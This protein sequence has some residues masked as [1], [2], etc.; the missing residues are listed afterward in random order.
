[1]EKHVPY[2][3]FLILCLFV[4]FSACSPTRYV[5]K[6]EFLLN[7]V[8]VKVEEQ[9]INTSGLKKAIRQRP[10][11]RILG[12]ARF[13]LGLYN[14][15][16][17]KEEKWLN[18]WLRSIGEAPVIYSPFLT[19]QSKTQLQ[20][21][22]NN[23]GYYKARVTDS[24]WFKKKKAYVE[25]RVVP[26][27][28]TK[29]GEFDFQVDS[30]WLSSGKRDRYR[31][32]QMILNDSANSLVKKEMP[33]D[34]EVLE[35]ERERIAYMLRKN[36]YFN[37]S[38]KFIH[39]Y[40]DTLNGNFSDHAGLLMSIVS[41]AY[42]TMSFRK[43]RINH[44]RVNLD[45]D[46]LR[47][48]G[49]K[50]SLGRIIPCEGYEV[51]Y[52]D[53][54]KIK[55]KVILETLQF[56]KGDLYNIQKV[57]SSY[58]R[59]QAL[60]LFKFINIVF[61]EHWD[62]E[63]MPALDCEIQLT[64]MKRQSYNVFLEGTNNS[65]NIG[66]G[67]NFSYNHRNLFHGGENITWS[68]WGALKKERL[69][70]NE[71]FSA[72]EVGTELKLISPQFWMPVFRMAEFR[73]NFAPKTSVSLSY[74]QE[75]TR[76]YRRRIASAKF[77]YFWRRADNKWHYNFDL[78]DLNY[79][80]MPYMDASF[81]SEL[82][83]EYVKSAY[84]DHMILSANFSATYTDQVVN[85]SESYNYFRG[86]VETS[87]N[88]LL[89]IDRLLGSPRT[90]QNGEKFHKM[91]GVRYAQFVKADGEYRF[92]HYVNKA[93]TVVYR[94][95][96]G[97]GYPYGNMK[98]LPFEEA[99]FCGGANGIR[100]WQSRTL[101]PGAYS[102]GDSYP[103]NVGDFKLEANIEYRFKLFWLLE[104]ALFLD[105]GN[106]WNINRYENRPGAHLNADFYQ[107]LAVGTGIGL[108]LDANFF[109]L[110]FDLGVKMRD[111]SLPR[112]QK[113]VLLNHNGGFRES[114]FNIAI[115]YPF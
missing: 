68:F 61:K 31:L 21:Y 92:S 9:G 97:C 107:Q 115:G 33:L 112:G 49:G 78:I 104:G 90:V 18:R 52:F 57:S 63:G 114:V 108:R 62:E 34:V 95:F 75:N 84:T 58:A 3:I 20:L 23:K 2:K 35:D 13:H 30:V 82:K 65:G 39:Y 77:G 86:N 59:L 96:L 74:S 8:K 85:T 67:G 32:V 40:A 81:I 5:G 89:G 45:Y 38:K 15:S 4:F 28:V 47:I 113:F 11:T 1:M 73:R 24:V 26:G 46:P 94:L 25:Y 41:N 110:R 76:F 100:A 103:N 37:F 51:V 64:P 70:E 91:L 93:N 36:G 72:T 80:L 106:I 43:Y 27:P 55:P 79:V 69:K 66:V 29:I 14:L 12:V 111:P 71:M 16:G 87:G 105:A 48:A 56:E 88:F 98:A 101:G 17:K 19:E 50:D 22:L 42:D 6:D 54:M 53:R 109:L 83:N 7:R 102:S 99:Y 44:I 10:N 60:N